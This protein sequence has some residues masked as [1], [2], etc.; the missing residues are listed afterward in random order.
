[1]LPVRPCEKAIG[2]GGSIGC[3]QDGSAKFREEIMD[4]EFQ[5]LV[6]AA[7][8]LAASAGGKPPGL[9]SNR[10]GFSLRQGVRL[11][12]TRKGNRTSIRSDITIQF[13]PHLIVIRIS[14]CADG[15]RTDIATAEI[16]GIQGCNCQ[17]CGGSRLK[18]TSARRNPEPRLGWNGGEVHL[19]AASCDR[20]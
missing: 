15:D 3:A 13:D 19:T 18:S 12:I 6:D 8:E 10:A 4:P 9:R 20:A 11:R 14:R 5:R 1:M 17:C 2:L 16:G 7:A